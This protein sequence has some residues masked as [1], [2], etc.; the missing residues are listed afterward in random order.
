[1]GASEN[2]GFVKRAFVPPM[3]LLSH[4]TIAHPKVTNNE[5]EML[6]FLEA[7]RLSNEGD[8]IVADSQ[9]I[10]HWMNRG[11]ARARPDLNLIIAE[12]RQLVVQKRLRAEW[13]PREE[14]D[15]GHYVEYVLQT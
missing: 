5:T 13:R 2:G 8:T 4:K 9:T 6:G 3:L 14:N 7:A 11:S 1:M 15:A 12:A 10:G